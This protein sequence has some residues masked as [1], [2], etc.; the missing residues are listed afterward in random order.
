[1]SVAVHQKISLGY[2]REDAEKK[3]NFIRF[4]K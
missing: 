3:I 4:L 1:M 2:C